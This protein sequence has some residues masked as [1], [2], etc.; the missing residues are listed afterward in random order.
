VACQITSKRR[1]KKPSSKLNSP[2]LISEVRRKEK[3]KNCAAKRKKRNYESIAKT[4]ATKG[5]Y[6]S[7]RWTRMEHFKFLEA[8]K[9][10]GKEW[11]KVQQHVFTRTSTQARSHAQKFFVKLDKKQ[12][13]L[14]EFLSRLD[15][16]QLKVDLR[17][18]DAGDSTE[19]DE[20]QPLLRIA[21][22]KNKGSV[23]NIA[24]PDE[25]TKLRNAQIKAAEKEHDRN[26]ANQVAVHNMV[27]I[28]EEKNI[29]SGSKRSN[30]QRKA[31]LNH[32]F[33][34][35]IQQSKE[36]EHFKRRRTGKEEE[37]IVEIEDDTKIRI[38][39]YALEEY[40]DSSSGKEH[41]DI[42]GVH[43]YGNEMRKG[44]QIEDI[45][46]GSESVLM[47]EPGKEFSCFSP[48]SVENV[49]ES[50]DVLMADK[51]KVDDFNVLPQ[52]SHQESNL[53]L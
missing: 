27:E 22:M 16:E 48:C 44:S 10:F 52:E 49:Q 43:D 21:N 8:L 23:M 34:H 38:N 29:Y 20:D 31:K 5:H 18:G 37:A 4:K 41:Q 15:I 47:D 12:L 11:Q 35:K 13:T 17:L 6:N 32:A 30:L 19:Y 25:T 33:L 7:G 26:V 42:T 2:Y 53:N 1:V 9:L 14:E 39:Q 36:K 3:S 45:L 50:I 40:N 28:E 51:P 46:E 24:L